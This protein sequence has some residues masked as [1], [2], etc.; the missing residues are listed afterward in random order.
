MPRNQECVFC[1]RVPPRRLPS[2][3]SG[4]HPRPS[5]QRHIRPTRPSLPRWSCPARRSGRCCPRSQCRPLRSRPSGPQGCSECCRE[6]QNTGRHNRK[7]RLIRIRARAPSKVSGCSKL[8]WDKLTG[9]SAWLG[10]SPAPGTPRPSFSPCQ[11]S[12]PRAKTRFFPHYGQAR[13]TALPEPRKTPTP[14]TCVHIPTSLPNGC[15][16][17]SASPAGFQTSRGRNCSHTPAPTLVR[18]SKCPTQRVQVL[19]PPPGNCGDHCHRSV[20]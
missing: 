12:P 19:P 15:T 2:P 8:F 10:C 17:S 7:F 13:R 18:N 11:R 4:T 20:I 5:H 3:C 16:V 14:I 9:T 1:G 6:A